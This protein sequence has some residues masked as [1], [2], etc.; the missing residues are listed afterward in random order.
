MRRVFASH[1]HDLQVLRQMAQVL[2]QKEKL[3]NESNAGVGNAGIVESAQLFA[4]CMQELSTQMSV[5][6]PAL[7]EICGALW[8]GFVG[9]FRRSIAIEETRFGAECGA[10]GKTR[11]MLEQRTADARH[12]QQA[13]SDSQR[14]LTERQR[15]MDEKDR[16]TAKLEANVLHEQAHLTRPVSHTGLDKCGWSGRGWSGRDWFGQGWSG[17]GELRQWWGAAWVPLHIIPSVCTRVHASATT[18]PR[19]RPHLLS[20][21]ACRAATSLATEADVRAP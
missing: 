12:W 21:P 17:R 15:K 20:L 6:S 3:D 19:A 16:A 9:L 13:Y 18:C 1:A 10:H 14:E 5:F 2:V 7:S 8:R 11:A 4:V